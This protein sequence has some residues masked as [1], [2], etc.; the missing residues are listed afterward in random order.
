MEI[1]RIFRKYDELDRK[2]REKCKNNNKHTALG[3]LPYLGLVMLCTIVFIASFFILLLEI[4]VDN[5]KRRHKNMVFKYPFL[6]KFIR[7]IL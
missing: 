7:F 4:F 3:I 1:K 5:V 2:Q 6:T